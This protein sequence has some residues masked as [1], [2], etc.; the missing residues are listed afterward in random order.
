MTQVKRPIQPPPTHNCP[1]C[2]RA[3]TKLQRRLTGTTGGSIIY[4]CAH[5]G[6]C[7]MAVNVSQVDT[8][9]AV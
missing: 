8:W 5:V 1:V 4:V 2:H 9:M 3:Q 7:S 6:E